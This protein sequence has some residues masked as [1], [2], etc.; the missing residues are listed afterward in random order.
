MKIIIG[1]SNRGKVREIASI[2]HPLGYD[3]EAKAFDVDEIGA[4]IEDNAVIKGV[5]YSLKNPGVLTVAEDSGIVVPALNDLPGPY[6][7][8][9][10]EIVLDGYDVLKVNKEE[11]TTDKTEHD[12]LN[13]ERLVEM[14][15]GIDLSNRAAYFEVCFVVAM[16]GKVL[17]KTSNRSYGYLIDEPRGE[18]GF[19]YDPIFVGNDTFGKTYAELDSARKNLKSHRKKALSELAFYLSQNFKA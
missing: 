7:A 18:N 19:G 8:R 4:T 5:E 11:F 16:D 9:F 1:T 2:L 13:N 15:K 3:L 10:H 6:S 17:Y 12:R 14:I